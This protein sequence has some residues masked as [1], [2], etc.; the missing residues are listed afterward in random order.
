MTNTERAYEKSVR[1]LI[2]CLGRNLEMEEEE[3]VFRSLAR[4]MWVATGGRTM[5][6]WIRDRCDH[7]LIKPIR[8]EHANETPLTKDELGELGEMLATLFLRKKDHMKILFQN[9]RAPHGGE[10]DI[11]CRDEDGLV[12]IEVKT[13]RSTTLGRPL[14]AVTE[15]KQELITRGAMEWL[16]LLGYPKIWFRFDVMEVV[17]EHGKPPNIQR[18]E[19]AFTLPDSVYYPESQ[20]MERR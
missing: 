13:R 11:V 19:N 12:F 8:L 17:L 5:W 18:I 2:S 14:D 6:R 7:S 20:A 1:R 3:N 4:S 9:F 10:V 16:R 15:D